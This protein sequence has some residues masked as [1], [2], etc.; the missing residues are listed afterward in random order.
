MKTNWELQ[1]IG[2]WRLRCGDRY[3]NVAAR[4]QHLIALLALQGA[5]PRPYAASLLW[6]DS[7]DA[8]ASGSLRATIL[9]ISRQLPGLMTTAP[10]RLELAEGTRIDVQELRDGISQAGLRDRRAM[11]LL[12]R[13]ELLPGWYD[14]WVLAEQEQWRS[15]RVTTLKTAAANRLEHEDAEGALETARAALQIDPLDENAIRLVLRAHLAEGNQARALS[16]YRD[17]SS[18]IRAELGAA[19]PADI[20]GLIRPLLAPARVLSCQA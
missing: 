14:D 4:Q 13:G 2:E 18:R 11:D 1:L 17:F 10:G 12:A 8:Q 9:A 5:K 7:S 19:L 16:D 20:T 3:L 15:F 6:P